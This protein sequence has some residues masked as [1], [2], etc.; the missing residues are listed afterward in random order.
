MTV[1]GYRTYTAYHPDKFVKKLFEQIKVL[2]HIA[3]RSNGGKPQQDI[4]IVQKS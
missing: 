2:S 1:E 3:T 4:W